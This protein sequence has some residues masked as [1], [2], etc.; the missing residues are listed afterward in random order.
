MVPETVIQKEREDRRELRQSATV[1][2]L[3]SERESGWG[4][5]ALHNCTADINAERIW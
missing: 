3:I 5:S 2:P 4:S 1:L